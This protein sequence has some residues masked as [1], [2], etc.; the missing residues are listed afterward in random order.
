MV[1]FKD[2][3]A[4]GTEILKD[5][6]NEAPAV[7]ARALLCHAAGCGRAYIYTHG[8]QAL[9]SGAWERYVSYL[10]KRTAGMPVQYIT[11]RCEFLALDFEVGPEVL[12]PRPDTEVLVE[13]AA[14]LLTA[15]GNPCEILDLGTGSG[16]IAVG[17]A[18]LLKSCTVTA[19]DV[20]EEALITAGRNAA[21]NGISDR[22]EFIKSDLFGSLEGRR[23][24]AVLS[25][26]PYIRSGDIPGL[27]R[28]VRDYEPRA[29]LDGGPDGLVFYRRIV[30]E[31][32]SYMKECGML[33]FEVGRG[34][35]CEVA[36]L[37]KRHYTDIEILKDLAGIERVVAG[38]LDS[39]GACCIQSP[40]IQP[41][42]WR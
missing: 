14:R 21:R 23:F 8:E 20:S 7:D 12:V 26:P 2:A 34:Q 10:G 17:I 28:E 11:G 19:V 27:Q 24:D 16:C 9:E 39:R 36:A 35:A 5:A 13:A 31:A 25:N 3:L 22:L 38:K 4:K 6:G 1:T 30:E 18:H 32:P 42:E 15:K 41:A 37:M 40:N 33:A 29:A